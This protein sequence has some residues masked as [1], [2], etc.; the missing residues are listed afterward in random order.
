MPN[1]PAFQQTIQNGVKPGVNQRV[2]RIEKTIK[3]CTYCHCDY[4][5]ED[6]CHGKFPHLRTSSSAG[7][8][9]THNGKITTAGKRKHQKP[10]SGTNASTFRENSGQAL[11]FAIPPELGCFKATSSSTSMKL[12][13]VWIWDSANSRHICHNRSAFSTFQAL[14]NQP[15]ITGLGGSVSAE[16]EGDIH[17]TCKSLDGKLQVLILNKFQYMLAAGVNLISQGQ[18]HREGLQM[19]EITS[20][21]IRIGDNMFARLVDNNLYLMDILSPGQLAL[22]AI[23]KD[24]LKIWHSCLGHLGHQN[25]IRLANMSQGIDLS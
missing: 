4:H 6:E 8:S 7:V 17:L 25:I 14:T 19:L 22:A 9:Q 1:S 2:L 10:N 20:Q 21:G 13:S 15:P 12:L 16:K 3:Y 23:N 5:T 11:F 24:T 18:I